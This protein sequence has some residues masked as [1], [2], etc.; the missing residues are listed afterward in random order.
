MP[1]LPLILFIGV[2]VALT[3]TGGGNQSQSASEIAAAEGRSTQAKYAC[4]HNLYTQA[5][6]SLVLRRTEKL[7]TQDELRTIRSMQARSVHLDNE[8]EHLP[9]RGKQINRTLLAEYQ[10]EQDRI[11]SALS[12]YG[13]LV[14]L[15]RRQERHLASGALDAETLNSLGQQIRESA[16]QLSERLA[17]LEQSADSAYEL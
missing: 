6:E 17:F 12:L 10:I 8:L 4:A 7:V 1:A 5:T 13:A 9:R 16:S 14:D 2:F 11:E 15:I 3:A